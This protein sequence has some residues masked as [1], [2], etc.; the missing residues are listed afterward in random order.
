M[1]KIYKTKIKLYPSGIKQ[2]TVYK[3]SILVK[4]SEKKV[5][6]YSE[7]EKGKSEEDFQREKQ[8]ELWKIKTKIKDYVLCNDFDQF[9]TLTF[10]SDRYDYSIAFE[11]MSKWLRKMRDK[12]GRFNYIV[13]PELHKDGAIH[14]HAVFGNFKGKLINSGKKHKNVTVWNSAD[15]EYGFT[16]ITRMRNKERCAS[17]VTKYF[18]KDMQNSIVGKNKKKYWLSRDLKKPVVSYSSLDLSAELEV[19]PDFESDMCRIYKIQS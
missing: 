15:W 8:R 19:E 17:Y 11:K 4:N 12:Y 18:T 7:V 5:T 6:L 10:N 14:F 13:I 2:L 9:W 16:T 3:D 1:T